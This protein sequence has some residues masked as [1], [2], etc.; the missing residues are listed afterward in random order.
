MIIQRYSSAP[1]NMFGVKIF[2][3]NRF[4]NQ[5]EIQFAFAKANITIIA[6][7]FVLQTYR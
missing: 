4:Y 2:I 5:I 1:E 7:T 3:S 6:H